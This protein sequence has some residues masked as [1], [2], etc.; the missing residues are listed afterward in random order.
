[1]GIGHLPFNSGNPCADFTI[2]TGAARFKEVLLLKDF[3]RDVQYRV[4]FH[5]AVYPHRRVLESLLSTGK[6]R[7]AVRGQALWDDE[8]A[9]ITWAS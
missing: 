7:F 6:A 9:H 1:M 2:D 3:R 4:W 5:R 8:P